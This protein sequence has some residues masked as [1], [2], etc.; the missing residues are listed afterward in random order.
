MF[1]LLIATGNP[2]KRIELQELLQDLPVRL[3]LPAEIGL[4]D[5][6]VIEDGQTYAENAQKKAL[7]YCQASGLPVLADDSGLEVDALGGAPGL[8]SARYA[9]QPGATDADRRALLG[10]LADQIAQLDGAE[11]ARQFLL[12]LAEQVRLWLD[13]R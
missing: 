10:E 1:T 4:E 2:G 6:D 5:F 11:Q 13:G 9:P 3:V 7:A 12:S 8:H